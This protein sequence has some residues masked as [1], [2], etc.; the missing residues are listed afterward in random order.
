M[1]DLKKWLSES[2]KT[3]G[4]WAVLFVV[5]WFITETIKQAIVIPEYYSLKVWEFYYLI[6]MRQ[7][8]VLGLTGLGGFIDKFLHEWGKEV[9]KEGWLGIKGL[10]GF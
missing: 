4:R 9:G 1:E 7:L 8:F 10:T 5:S 6:P 2:G 3:V